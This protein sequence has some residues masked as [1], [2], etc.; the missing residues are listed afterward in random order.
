MIMI[1]RFAISGVSDDF[2]YVLTRIIIPPE[3][4]KFISHNIL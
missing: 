3:T 2:I 4:M 1:T